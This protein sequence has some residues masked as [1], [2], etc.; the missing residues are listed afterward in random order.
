M[1]ESGEQTS[2]SLFDSTL[3][4][5]LLQN[6]KQLIKR[7]FYEFDKSIMDKNPA[8]L[9]NRV[10]M[11]DS[12]F[13]RI[14]ADERNTEMKNF[15]VGLNMKRLKKQLSQHMNQTYSILL[16]IIQASNQIIRLSQD[17]WCKYLT[18]SSQW[19]G[20]F[21]LDES[22]HSLPDYA[23]MS[24]LSQ[25]IIHIACQGVQ[26][27]RSYYLSIVQKQDVWDTKNMFKNEVSRIIIS[28]NFECS[29]MADLEELVLS[30]VQQWL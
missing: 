26:Q 6:V 1:K 5:K 15:T 8:S 14:H 13:L 21:I 9:T 23:Q 12:G 16:T 4:R 28:S 24:P 27:V 19:M 29:T 20:N 3:E 7:Q 25:G 17:Q 10:T 2:S 11:L 18:D 30:R 22:R